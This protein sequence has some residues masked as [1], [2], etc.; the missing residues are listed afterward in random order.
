MENEQ[1]ISDKKNKLLETRVNETG[2]SGSFGKSLKGKKKMKTTYF[3]NPINNLAGNHSISTKSGTKELND[4]ENSRSS[5]EVSLDNVKSTGEKSNSPIKESEY[6]AILHDLQSSEDSFDGVRWK[7][8]P[9][10][11]AKFKNNYPS[12]PLKNIISPGKEKKPLNLSSTVINEQLNSVLVKYGSDFQNILSQ[13][14]KVKRLHSDILSSESKNKRKANYP[15]CHKS[16]T[17]VRAKSIGIDIL[18]SDSR[19]DTK[20]TTGESEKDVFKYSLNSWIDKFDMKDLMLNP[21]SLKKDDDKVQTERG[22]EEKSEAIVQSDGSKTKKPETFNL[23]SIQFS[24][25]FSDT[26]SL[27]I[28]SP[29]KNKTKI[30]EDINKDILKDVIP[31]K[32]LEKPAIEDEDVSDDPF[33]EDEDEELLQIEAMLQKLSMKPSAK[34]STPTSHIQH[35]P[36]YKDESQT[37]NITKY[38]EISNKFNDSLKSK[39][40]E[41]KL[42]F[43]RPDLKRF[44]I[45]NILVKEYTVNNHKRRQIIL[46]V[47]NDKAEKQ[48]LIVRGEYANLNLEIDDII[49]IIVTD[50]TNPKL[51]D[52][53]KNLLIWNPDILVSATTVSQQISCPRKT[54][55]VTRF[56]FPGESSVPLL[57]GTIIHSIF[58]ECFTQENWEID[59]MKNMMN[60]QINQNLLE[61]FSLGPDVDK[62]RVEIENHLPYLESWFN[63]YYKQQLGNN[64]FIPTNKYNQMVMF[65]ATEALDVEENIWS[66]M[67]GIKGMVDVTL[68][69]NLRDKSLN[70]K[71]L[72]PMEIKTGREYISHQA[73]SSLYSLLFKDRYDMD[74]LSFLLVYTKERITKKYDISPTD[75]KSLINLRNRI[76]E[77]LKENTSKLPGLLKQ[78][79]CERCEV[80]QSCMTLNKLVEE[81]KA[82]DSGLPEGLYDQLTMHLHDN[83]KYKEF[84]TYWEDLITKEESII[85]KMKKDLWKYTAQERELDSGKALGNL[86]IK[87]SNDSGNMQSEFIYTFERRDNT[88]SNLQYSQLVKYDR[89]IISDETG[90]FAIAQ[91]SILAIRQDYIRIST[92]RRIIDSELKLSGFNAH[93]NQ[94]FKGVLHKSQ[95]PLL[96][97][98]TFRI[99]KDDMFHGLGLARY[100]ILNLFLAEGDEKRRRIVVD[101]K[102]PEF[103]SKPLPFKMEKNFNED[104][105]R[106]FKKVLSAKDYALILGMPG[107]GKTTVIAELIRF[108]VENN[109]TI[110]LASYT[111]SAVDNIL[112]KVKEFGIGI[113]RVGFHSR[114]HKDIKQFIPGFGNNKIETYEQFSETYMN[115]PVVA[116]TCLGINDLTF[117]LR[118]HFDYCIIDEATQVTMPVSLGPLRFCDKFVLVGDHFQLQPLVKHPHPKVKKGLSQSLFKMLA[119][120]HP[121]STVE[122]TYQYRMCEE[123]MYLSNALIYENRLKCGSEKVAKQFLKIPYPERLESTIAP[124]Y[125]GMPDKHWL[126]IV[127]NEKNKVIFLNHDKVPAIERKIG[128]KIENHIEAELITQIVKSLVASGVDQSEIGVMSFYRSQLRLLTRSLVP[129][130]DVEIL[131]A[132]QFQGRDKECI[133]I[134]LVRSNKDSIVG[135]LLKEWRRINVALTRSKSK[136]IILG[137]KST[138]NNA[139]TIKTFLRLIEKK[140][141]LYDLPQGANKIYEFPSSLN[142]K[143]SNNTTQFS[144]QNII[145]PTIVK[146]HPIIN[147]IIRDLATY[148]H[149]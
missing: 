84:Y 123:I 141:W 16:P 75:L 74:V 121:S 109:K 33:S 54:L 128:E 99:D 126:D 8:S 95:K 5:N 120:T 65:S 119:E 47:I 14:P 82:E 25:D 145:N 67:F 100:N 71:Y 3:F 38:P 36:I 108:L 17:L 62:I 122:L 66:P 127:F 76:T 58:Q 55:L 29:T 15:I 129:E 31:E 81:G 138:M 114:V 57:V 118:D 90:H 143:S 19:V 137:S 72:L 45:K 134:S 68:E 18:K 22:S 12:S 43:T 132:D 41:A 139:D 133:I 2:R 52:D 102:E 106:A 73:Q 113:L 86:V 24:D 149:K 101:L 87:D 34:A 148:V 144:S 50:P 30:V 1:K 80:Q 53:T 70:G 63:T 44:Q 85:T 10:K 21:I 9:R 6:E 105:I 91:G 142:I 110:L 83:D 125:K 37:F 79:Q 59:N 147:D 11:V 111:H 117:N 26:S 146:N 39:V 98:K 107:S 56:S 49:H 64:S 4:D 140:G 77:F 46:D 48:K 27:M 112:L 96:Q 124:N 94:T 42:S 97:S 88:N 35:T 92:S 32:I 115:P 28:S 93:N 103:N 130:F 7:V 89:V 69:A 51:V 40:D 136:L 116:A 60:N 20:K 13:T 104:Q 23:E 78:S 135:D 61:I 131:T